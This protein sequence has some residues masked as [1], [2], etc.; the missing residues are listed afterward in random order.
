MSEQL[1]FYKTFVQHS[2]K[3]KTVFIEFIKFYNT[4]N[5]TYIAQNSSTYILVTKNYKSNEYN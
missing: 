4:L 5:N 2:C 3:I 1:I